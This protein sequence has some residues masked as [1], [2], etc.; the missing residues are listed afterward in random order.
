MPR[1][2][3]EYMG[4]GVCRYRVNRQDR[5]YV[6]M[7]MSKAEIEAARFAATSSVKEKKVADRNVV[8]SEREILVPLTL[9][10]DKETK[11]QLRARL[12][13]ALRIVVAHTQVS[14]EEVAETIVDANVLSYV[15]QFNSI[16]KGDVWVGIMNS[17]KVQLGMRNKLTANQLNM[18]RKHMATRQLRPLTD[19]QKS[20]LTANG[21]DLSSYG[22]QLALEFAFFE[23]NRRRIAAA[24]D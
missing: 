23:V 2:S 12:E 1:L 20:F 4:L 17:I 10:S 3:P 13:E 19:G 7:V 11:A 14:V 18:V 6:S 9:I 16:T 15:E 5:R 8:V 21:F 22:D 24:K